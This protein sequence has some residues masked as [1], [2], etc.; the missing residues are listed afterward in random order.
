MQIKLIFKLRFIFTQRV[1]RKWPIGVPYLVVFLPMAP[2]AL[3]VLVYNLCSH[4]KWPKNTTHIATDYYWGRPKNILNFS[5]L[6]A[7]LAW[8][9]TGGRELKKNSRR[10]LSASSDRK[11]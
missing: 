4:P 1:T 9:T 10:P 6:I 8:L 2:C 3:T 7:N 11:N 5:F